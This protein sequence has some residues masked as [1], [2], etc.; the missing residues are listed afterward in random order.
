MPPTPRPTPPGTTSGQ[1]FHA[2]LDFARGVLRFW[3]LKKAIDPGATNANI[4]S[5]IDLVKHELSGYELPGAGG[6]GFLFMIARDP[7]SAARVRRILERRPPNNLA[8]FYEPAID[9]HGMSISVL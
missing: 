5:L 7:D 2:E 3:E 8:R 6:G 1:D 9:L 4:E